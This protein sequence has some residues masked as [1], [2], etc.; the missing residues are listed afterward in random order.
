MKNSRKRQFVFSN[1]KDNK[2]AEGKSAFKSDEI[3]NLDNEI[4]IGLT[5]VLASNKKKHSKKK[6]NN[7]TI[8]KKSIKQDNSYEKTSRES[9]EFSVYKKGIKKNKEDTNNKTKNR[10]NSNSNDSQKESE[11]NNS[12]KTGKIKIA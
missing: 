2:K 7:K 4:V 11:K 6:N 12:K 1:V 10:K 9:I 8:A 3:F 5:P